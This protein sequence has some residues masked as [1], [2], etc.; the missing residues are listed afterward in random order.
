MGQLASATEVTIPDAAQTGR[1]DK[2]FQELRVPKSNARAFVPGQRE[3]PVPDGADQ[4]LF[5]LNELQFSGGSVFDSN[6]L[7][8]LAGDLIGQQ[9]SLA[10]LYAIANRVTVFYRNNGY[11]L[12]QAV[13]PEQTIDD[14]GIVNLHIVEGYIETLSINGLAGKQL[15]RVERVAQN[16]R[17][18]RPLHAR[19]LERYLLVLNDFGGVDFSATL[20]PSELPGAADMQLD[21]I[22]DNVSASLGLENRGS[23]ILGPERLSAQVNI[24]NITGLFDTTS[25]TAVSSG[26]DEL[27]YAS[28]KTEV[29]VGNNGWRIFSS[30]AASR[31][32][33]GDVLEV[34]DID[35]KSTTISI[36]AEYPIIRARKHN[37][38]LRT[39]L[40]AY[41]GE[42]TRLADAAGAQELAT[43]DKVRSLRF[44]LLFDNIDA[45]RGVNLVDLELSRGLDILGASQAGDAGLSRENGDPEY[46]KLSLYA[47]RLQSIAPRWSLLMALSGQYSSDDLL[48]TEQFGLGGN[49]FG[50]A[51]DPSEVV[52]DSGLG[53]RLELRYSHASDNSWLGN[54]VGY[55]FLDGGKIKRNSPSAGQADSESLRSYGIGVRYAIG[56]YLSG[57]VEYAVPQNREV[58]SRSNDDGRLFFNVKAKL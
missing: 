48:S 1:I 17:Q 53:G 11:I 15:S 3:L 12:S 44:G 43:E 50:S 45:Y 14:R 23:R 18:S 20:Q 2:E 56:R 29:P 33:P 35:N 36:G 42:S 58:A 55:A 32:K 5:Q 52:G 24:H 49:S 21:V 41:E 47:A 28:V 54:A 27:A 13:V 37:L 9:V 25:L 6:E 8:A 57:N 16:I 26:N 40:E 34:L 30:L 22:Q 31:S 10:D 46:T 19:D 7:I 4:V 51:F 39:N 38:S